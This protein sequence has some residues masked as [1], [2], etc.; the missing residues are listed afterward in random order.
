MSKRGQEATSNDGDSK[1]KTCE[2]GGAQPAPG[3]NFILKFGISNQ[4]REYR[5]MEC[6]NRQ[7]V[8]KI[9]QNV[10]KKLGMSAINAIF[11]I[12][13]YKTNALTWGLF[14]ALSMRAAIHLG[15][16]FSMNSEIFK[17]TKFEK[18]WNLFN[19]TQKLIKGHSEEF[20]NVE[21]LEYNEASIIGLCFGDPPIFWR[22]RSFPRGPL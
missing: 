12:D 14:W 10:E 22:G 13:S 19:I 8:G 17:N 7:Y 16:H 11:S 15:P 6:T 5:N 2:S 1:S 20:L 4:S 18:I 9:F 3:G 21:S